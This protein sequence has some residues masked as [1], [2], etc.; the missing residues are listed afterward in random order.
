LAEMT[1]HRIGEPVVLAPQTL[2]FTVELE[3]PDA[4]S[5]G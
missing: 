5:W 1:V 2:R 4:P 3:P